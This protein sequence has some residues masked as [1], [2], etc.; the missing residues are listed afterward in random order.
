MGTVVG[1]GK[2]QDMVSGRVASYRKTN[3]LD[4]ATLTLSDIASNTTND[5]HWI[6]S[7]DIEVVTTAALFDPLEGRESA[8]LLR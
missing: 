1:D 7:R 6:K 4:Q 2:S 3:C 5:F 8:P